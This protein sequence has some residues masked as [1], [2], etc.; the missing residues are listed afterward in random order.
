MCIGLSPLPVT[1]ANQ[2][3]VRDPLLKKTCNPRG[4]WQ[5]GPGDNPKMCIIVSSIPPG[6]GEKCSIAGPM[7]GRA[8]F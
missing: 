6:P 2:G 5:P 4:D 7:L 8:A 3:L 1:V